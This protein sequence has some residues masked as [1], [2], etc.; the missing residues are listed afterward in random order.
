[1]SLIGEINNLKEN[2]QRSKI[3][4]IGRGGEISKT[5][6]LKDLANALYN[7]PAD[8]SLSFVTDE[9]IAYQKT[10][11]KNSLPYAQIKKIGGMCYKSKNLIPFPYA[12][13]SKTEAGITWTV[14]EDGSV[15]VSG[16]ATEN[17]VFYLYDAKKFPPGISKGTTVRVSAGR[18]AS[19]VDTSVTFMA[20]Y[21]REEGG[22]AQGT[23]ST[24]SGNTNTWTVPENATGLLFYLVAIKGRIVNHT[25]YPQ[26]E[27]GTTTTEYEPYFS[28]LRNAK[29]EEVKSEGVNRFDESQIT[30]AAHQN[31]T[32]SANYGIVE[33]GVL[34][35][36]IGY[37]SGGIVWKPFEMH[38]K[39][40]SYTISADCFIPAEGAPSLQVYLGL[41][42]LTKPKYYNNVKTLSA[43][44]AWERVSV[45][46]NLEQDGVCALQAQGTGGPSQSSG[47][48]VR[49]KNIS[50]T[51][52]GSSDFKSYV[53]TLDIF[54]IPQAVQD[55]DGY[56]V[57]VNADFYNHVDFQAKTFVKKVGRV[58][59]GTLDFSVYNSNENRIVFT[60]QVE[61]IK[62]HYNGE[63]PAPILADGYRTVSQEQTWVAGDI[64]QSS[65]T[66]DYKS[67]RVVEK[68]DVTLEEFKSLV[69]GRMLYYA[70]ETPEV[71][72]ISLILQS[73]NFIKVEGGST[74]TFE[75]E[76]KYS[77]PSTIKYITKV[78]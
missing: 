55:L 58:D 3:A 33:N 36:K 7:I 64:A 30:Y 22:T 49:F 50:I 34:I 18:D 23:A 21:Y 17:S 47:M 52:N 39:K 48:D 51:D 13:D 67:I 45:T 11:P 74:L 10:A 35:A 61:N 66:D 14:N 43:F 2:L 76:Y 20:N 15:S 4:I 37:Y 70:L 57:G 6:G 42:N 28:G 69:N 26:I 5:A 40:G 16:T 9:E 31:G 71:T 62:T 44:D 77:V 68:A 41:R 25:V 38:L 63:T 46:I 27:L 73:D 53:G 56:G 29:V 54:A 72:D 60:A 12:N 32:V 59:L 78:V 1:M 65:R 75:N 24:S 19:T 8:T